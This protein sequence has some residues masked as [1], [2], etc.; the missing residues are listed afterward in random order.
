ML[1]A[2]QPQPIEFYRQV[3][4]AGASWINLMDVSAKIQY[5]HE[6]CTDAYVAEVLALL[7]PT[8][9]NATALG[10]VDKLYVYG[11]DEI[12]SSLNATVYKLAGAIKSRWPQLR[13]VA[14]LDWP[15]MPADLPVDVS[16][17][18]T[19]RKTIF[20]QGAKL[21]NRKPALA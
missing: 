17:A 9:A 8:V 1:Y 14:A 6:N 21:S 4:D 7:A 10:I 3:A 11:F 20:V 18:F 13:I 16:G 15:T 5:Q 2:T 12:D 19:C